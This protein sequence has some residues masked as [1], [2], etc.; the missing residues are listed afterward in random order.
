MTNNVTY[1]GQNY[2]F[3]DADY[4]PNEIKIGTLYHC[5]WANSRGCVWKLINILPGNQVVLETPKTKRIITTNQF[6][7][8]LTNKDAK[9]KALVRL[10]KTI[11]TN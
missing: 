8:R 2:T 10:K 1:K 11:V 9:A 3:I 6:D 5:A 4:I 7:L